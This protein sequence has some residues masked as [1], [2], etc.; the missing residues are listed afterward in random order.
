[1]FRLDPT[2]SL[3]VSSSIRITSSTSGVDASNKTTSSKVIILCFVLGGIDQ[4][5]PALNIFFQYNLVLTK[6][7]FNL[8]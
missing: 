8:P 1:M 5:E 6:P 2:V 7:G 3:R 4:I